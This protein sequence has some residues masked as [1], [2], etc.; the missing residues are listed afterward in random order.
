MPESHPTLSE[1]KQFIIRSLE[2]EGVTPE[3]I[4]DEQPLFGEGL[5][6]DSVDAL[7]LL[8]AL[9]QRFKVKIT[10][11]DTDPRFFESVSAMH[12]FICEQMARS[13]GATG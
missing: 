2:L 7:E 4:E 1:L 9:E 8:V 13:A 3:D 11:A 10:V 6:L 12:R 5:G